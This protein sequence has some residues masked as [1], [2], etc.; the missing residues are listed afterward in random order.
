MTEHHRNADAS[1]VIGDI[2]YVE[3]ADEE[4]LDPGGGLDRVRRKPG[5]SSPCADTRCSTT[6]SFGK[7]ASTVG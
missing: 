2:P 4:F 5:S 3:L 1:R 7:C 6:T